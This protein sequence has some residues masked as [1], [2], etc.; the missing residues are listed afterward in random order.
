MGDGDK[1]DEGKDSSHED[2]GG[3]ATAGGAGNPTS[4]Q[5]SNVPG[6]SSSGKQSHL[7]PHNATVLR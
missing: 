1:K 4:P 5:S 7:L 2:G 6:I 3:G